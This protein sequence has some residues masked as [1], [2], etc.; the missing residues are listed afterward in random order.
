[1]SPA[2]ATSRPSGFA[3]FVAAI[4]QRLMNYLVWSCRSGSDAEDLFQEVCI[5][6]H[7]HWHDVKQMDRPEAWVIRVAHNRAANRFKRRDAERRALDV[8]RRDHS[9]DTPPTDAATHSRELGAA[10]RSALEALPDDQREAVAQKIWGNC[11]WIE[12]GETLGVSDDTAA[13]LF[14]RGLRQLAPMLKGFAPGDVA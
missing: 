8:R 9:E 2:H 10:V 11:T 13:R 1:M 5:T 4:E 6:L 7:D 12:I 3:G 14:A